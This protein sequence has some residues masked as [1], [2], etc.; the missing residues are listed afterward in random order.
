MTE[1]HSKFNNVAKASLVCGLL[2]VLFPIVAGLGARIGVWSYM[3]G[4]LLVP[5]GLLSALSAVILGVVAMLRLRKV[6]GRLV[7]SAHGA[8]VGLLMCLYLGSQALAMQLA[9]R[10][11]N[12]STDIE[13]PPAFTLAPTL[14]PESSNPLAYESERIGP[15]QREA[16]PDLGPLVV[17][18]VRNELHG[19]VKRVLEEMGMT[20]TRDD[21]AAGEIEAV[22]TTFWFGFKDD[23]VVRLRAVEDGTRMDVRS[24]SRVGIGD[25]NA[26][27]N[28]IREVIKRVQAA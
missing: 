20:V 4:A 25:V 8:G 9:P 11:H 5:V 23:L 10:I 19:R 24:V 27:A 21:P 17:S 3:V 15:I 18:V 22:A 12:I 6:G 7:V 28:R 26:N 2:G 1:A 14:R 13:D 16:Y